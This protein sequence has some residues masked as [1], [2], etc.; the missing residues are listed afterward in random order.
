MEMRRKDRRLDRQT[1]LSLLEQCEYA[2][3][4]TVNEDGTPYG[5]PVSPV[6]EGR[7]LYFHCALEG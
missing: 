7:N 2:V 5:I 1:A 3:V 6:L 4:S